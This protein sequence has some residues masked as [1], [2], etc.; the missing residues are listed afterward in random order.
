MLPG[1]RPLEE[2]NRMESL[3]TFRQLFEYDHWANQES[4]LSIADLSM[5]SDLALKIA[6]RIVGAKRIGLARLAAPDITPAAPWPLMN[7]KETL[8]AFSDLHSR[9]NS[10]LDQLALERL[11]EDLVH[12]YPKGDESRVPV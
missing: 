8:A 10:F 5:I 4:L 6:G 12:R 2:A 11:G 7:L 9:W 1:D 3:D